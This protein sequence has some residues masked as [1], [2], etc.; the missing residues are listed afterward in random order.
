MWNENIFQHF[1]FKNAIYKKVAVL[2]KLNSTKVKSW[3][4]LSSQNI[5]KFNRIENLHIELN[6][7]E[8]KV[9]GQIR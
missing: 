9:A 2:Q 5:G 1:I 6:L 4:I 8:I 3:I 7:S